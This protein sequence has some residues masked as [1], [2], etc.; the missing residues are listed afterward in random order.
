MNVVIKRSVKLMTGPSR[1]NPYGY[2]NGP[3][4]SNRLTIVA[5]AYTGDNG[6][7]GFAFAVLG[8]TSVLA[9]V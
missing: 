8:S 4:A 3:V 2:V 7:R 6:C 1:T 5:E 9:L